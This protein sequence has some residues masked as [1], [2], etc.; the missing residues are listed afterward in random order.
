MCPIKLKKNTHVHGSFSLTSK[1]RQKTVSKSS[2]ILQSCGYY[3][4]IKAQVKQ[5]YR[6]GRND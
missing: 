4:E 5:S 2:S 3:K 1:H 6:A